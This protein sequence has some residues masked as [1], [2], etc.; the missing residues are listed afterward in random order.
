MVNKVTVMKID[1]NCGV[2]DA[3]LFWSCNG[4]R[5]AGRRTVDDR[6]NHR[7][8]VAWSMLIGGPCIEVVTVR[9]GI[10]WEPPV[11]HG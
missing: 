9:D 3:C 11:R 8:V 4:L 6:S 2:N 7:L 10:A 1:E 5:I